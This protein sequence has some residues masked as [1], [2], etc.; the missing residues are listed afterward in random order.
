MKNSGYCLSGLEQ[1]FWCCPPQNPHRQA[2]KIW[3]W[4]SKGVDWNLVSWL[5]IVGFILGRLQKPHGYGPGHCAPSVSSGAVPGPAGHTSA[6]LCFYRLQVQSSVVV[7]AQLYAQ[8]GTY[9]L[10]KCWKQSRKLLKQKKK[11]KS[12][13]NLALCNVSLLVSSKQRQRMQGMIHFSHHQRKIYQQQFEG[14][15][16]EENQAH[17]VWGWAVIS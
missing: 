14:S 8:R 12:K 7:R 11:K 3:G 1:D 17:K 6:L 10:S 4:M 9:S 2:A 5:S 15:H 16:C 13:R